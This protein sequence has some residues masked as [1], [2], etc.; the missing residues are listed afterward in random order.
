M[1][2]WTRSG[3]GT[4]PSGAGATP[5]TGDYA[6]DTATAP[7]DFDPAAVTSVRIQ[8]TVTGTGFDEGEVEGASTEVVDPDDT[9]KVFLS[10]VGNGCCTGLLDDL[11]HVKLR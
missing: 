8:W 9:A 5:M 1:A 6:L 10:L 11:H 7:T 4:A 3:T 2:T